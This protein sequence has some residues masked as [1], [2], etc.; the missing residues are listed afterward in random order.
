MVD[1][2]LGYSKFRKRYRVIAVSSDSERAVPF[3]LGPR[4]SG[5]P[6]RLRGKVAVQGGGQKADW[7][8]AC[9]YRPHRRRERYQREPETISDS[10]HGV[11]WGYGGG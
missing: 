1:G 4:F 9:R 10:E 5:S 7:K 2:Y 11:S 3:A 6:L 8:D